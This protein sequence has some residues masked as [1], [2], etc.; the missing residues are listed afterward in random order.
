MSTKPVKM[1]FSGKNLDRVREALQDAIGHHRNEIGMLTDKFD[2]FDE[3]RDSHEAE[4][5]QLEILLDRI[6][7]KLG[8][9]S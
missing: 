7:H 4:I 9:P 1:T 8:I 6:D 3:V 2:P 5:T